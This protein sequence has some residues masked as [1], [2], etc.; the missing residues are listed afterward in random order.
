MNINNKKK[1]TIKDKISATQSL[2][3]Q[4]MFFQVWN[5]DKL[6]WKLQSSVK[7]DQKE[8]KTLHGRQWKIL[9]CKI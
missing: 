8:L 2:Y 1:G 9:Q 6:V 4:T 5:G 3:I 7:W